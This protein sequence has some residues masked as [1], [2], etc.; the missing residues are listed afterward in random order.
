MQRGYTQDFSKQIRNSVCREDRYSF[1]F[2]IPSFLEGTQNTFLG[3]SVFAVMFDK[4][5]YTSKN[6]ERFSVLRVCC[7][8]GPDLTHSSYCQCLYSQKG[9]WFSPT[10]TNSFPDQSAVPGLLQ[11]SKANGHAASA[12]LEA[13]HSSTTEKIVSHSEESGRARRLA[14]PGPSAPSYSLVLF[15]I[16]CKLQRNCCVYRFKINMLW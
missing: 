12:A 3:L 2:E 1:G 5:K 9:Q 8:R 11:P 6:F 13:L 16:V 7:S 14:F 15:Q 4:S 10:L